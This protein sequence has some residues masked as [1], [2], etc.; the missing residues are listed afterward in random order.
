MS[1]HYKQHNIEALDVISDWQLNYNLGAVIKY[2][3]R[4][5][6]KGDKHGD[7]KKAIDYI[8]REIFDDVIKVSREKENDQIDTNKAQYEPILRYDDNDEK[9]RGLRG[10][11]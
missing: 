10:G 8:R 9:L 7:L 11:M 6:Y 2:I 3:A 1:D 4:C 5:R